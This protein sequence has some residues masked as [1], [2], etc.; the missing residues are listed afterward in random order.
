MAGL[1]SLVTP[2]VQSPAYLPSLATPVEETA[3]TDLPTSLGN[4][5]YMP[6]PEG[7]GSLD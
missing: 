6:F 4:P 2:V 5:P 1:S 7:I 3:V